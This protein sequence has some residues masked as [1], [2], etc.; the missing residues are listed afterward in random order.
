MLERV[1]EHLQSL[2]NAEDTGRS[3]KIS[4]EFEDHRGLC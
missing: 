2:S 1:K 3:G 4:D